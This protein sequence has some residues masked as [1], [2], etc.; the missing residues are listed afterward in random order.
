MNDIKIFE[1]NNFGEVRVAEV[2]GEPMFCL[3]DVCRI[4]S[5]QTGATKNRL[6]EKGINSIKTLTKGG[7]QNM[8]YITEKN[9]YRAIMRSDK[10]EAIAFQDWVCDE[11]L[12]SIRKTG[13]YEVTRPSYQISDPIKRAE[14]WIEEEK[15]RQ[16]LELE[17]KEQQK[18]IEVM[19]GEIVEHKMIA[20]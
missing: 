18:Q 1:N 9:L 15:Q 4:L 12:P 2:N 10:D 14:K 7:E 8:L 3:A 13:K 19:S 20:A 16:H 11:V 17:N 6:D 5:L